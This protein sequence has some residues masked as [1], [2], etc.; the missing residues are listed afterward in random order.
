[1]DKRDLA[2]IFLKNIEEGYDN[3][4]DGLTCNY[5]SWYNN[6]PKI[7]SIKN[8]KKYFEKYLKKHPIKLPKEMILELVGGCMTQK[9]ENILKKYGYEI[10]NKVYEIRYSYGYHF[11]K[12]FKFIKIEAPKEPTKEEIIETI[13]KNYLVSEY[14]TITI[15]SIKEI[16]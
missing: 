6:C 12:F 8:Y 3:Y 7:Y 2:K 11:V 9:D 13:H 14:F 4:C 10:M 15:D 5:C 1:M 16:V